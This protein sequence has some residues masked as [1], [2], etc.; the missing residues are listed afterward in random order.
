MAGSPN[1]DGRLQE[2]TP[3]KSWRNRLIRLGKS[4]WGAGYGTPLVQ[5]DSV[6][7][8]TRVAEQEVLQ[9][10]DLGSGKCGETGIRR[11]F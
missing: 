9:C 7:I 5:G 4:K 8:H 1:R 10:L 2:F 3:P 6:F 11:A